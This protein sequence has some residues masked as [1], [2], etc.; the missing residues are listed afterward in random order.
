MSINN[1]TSTTRQAVIL[2][3]GKGTRML[4]FT[5]SVP[6]PL[7]ELKGRPLLEYTMLA[8]PREV[9]E[10]ILVVGYMGDQI[11]NRF[12]RRFQNYNIFYAEQKEPKGTFNALVAASSMLRDNFLLLMADDIYYRD[13]IENMARYENAILVKKLTGNSEK[14]GHCIE[15]S[16]LLRDLLEKPKGIPNPLACCGAY[17]LSREILNEPIIYGPNGEEVLSPM[18]GTFAKKMPIHVVEAKFW[19][20]IATP[21]DLK[22]AE[23]HSNIRNNV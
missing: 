4:P 10:I 3:A 13:D 1:R 7:M 18:I 21:E 6:K 19:H 8:L 9:S 22:T 15:K 17:K 23:Q 12:G 16:G 20:P 2:A 11:K 5:Q 14:F